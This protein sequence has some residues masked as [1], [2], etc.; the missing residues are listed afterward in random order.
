MKKIIVSILIIISLLALTVP[1]KAENTE[2]IG[3]NLFNP[4]LFEKDGHSILAFRKIPL[5]PNM[6]YTFSMHVSYFEYDLAYDTGRIRAFDE[7]GDYFDFTS[8]THDI[9]SYIDQIISCTFT[10][11]ALSSGVYI[12]FYGEEIAGSFDNGYWHQEMQLEAGTKRTN[13]EAYIGQEIADETPPVFQGQGYFITSYTSLLS[14]ETIISENISAYDDID[15]DLTSDIK[16]IEDHYSD[17]IGKVGEHTVLLEVED[18][19]HNKTQ[20]SLVII[21]KDEILPIITGPDTVYVDVDMPPNLEEII[22]QHYSFYDDY[23][24]EL[25]EYVIL[26]DYY[27]GHKNSIGLKQVTI[28]ISDSSLNKTQKTIN[29]MVEDTVAPVITGDTSLT[30]SLSQGLMI[31]DLL[32]FYEVTDNYDLNPVIII[33]SHT[34]IDELN[35]LGQYTMILKA[36]DTSG[37]ETTYQVSVTIIDDIKPV[38]LGQRYYEISYTQALDLAWIKSQLSILD[39]Y[40]DLNHHDLEK[41]YDSYTPNQSNPGLYKVVYKL[42]DYSGNF[43]THTFFIQ[44]V[45]DQAPN[46]TFGANITLELGSTLSNHELFTI[47]LSMPNIQAYNPVEL[48]LISEIDFT[49]VGKQSVDVELINAQGEKIIET[50]ML[51][52]VVPQDPPSYTYYYVIASLTI[53][54]SITVYFVIKRKT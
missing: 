12:D 39:N 11:S 33:D 3:K 54:V 52:I 48:E 19:S 16:I 23:D 28:E 41:I 21:I 37:N 51:H 14:L 22:E 13:Y 36:T 53:M 45:D 2:P 29:I 4:A 5:E 47:L 32:S 35:R 17:N 27:S 44:V 20:F 38:I 25:F 9:C 40:D 30:I 10:T 46:F 49:V 50:I 8:S 42:N 6:T 7:Y 1:L 31:N 24:K 26:D 34:F 15:G 43:T 18:S